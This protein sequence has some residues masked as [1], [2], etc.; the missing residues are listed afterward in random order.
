MKNILFFCLFC[1]FAANA[2]T[3]AKVGEAKT[4]PAFGKY[5]ALAFAKTTLEYYIKNADTVRKIKEKHKINTYIFFFIKENVEIDKNK[6]K[7]CLIWN[8]NK[9]VFTKKD[10]FP[11]EMNKNDT[12]KY[13]FIE[14]IIEKDSVLSKKQHILLY[15]NTNSYFRNGRNDK[16]Q[17][18]EV[19]P[20]CDP[21]TIKTGKTKRI[22]QIPIACLNHDADFVCNKKTKKWLLNT[23]FERNVERRTWFLKRF[24]L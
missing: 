10:A 11:L 24:L 19:P 6:I 13:R 14:I 1:C 12:I 16:M 18:V 7:D 4:S 9:A 23:D 20:D 8:S 17:L 3:T 21:E 5:D 15:F 22:T 2:Q